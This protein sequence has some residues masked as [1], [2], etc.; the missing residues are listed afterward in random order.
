[1]TGPFT[2]LVAL[3]GGPLDGAR[4]LW[5][6]PG[7]VICGAHHAMPAADQA[8][9]EQLARLDLARCLPYRRAGP[10]EGGAAYQHAPKARTPIHA[11]C[12]PMAANWKRRAA[13]GIVAAS[14]SSGSGRPRRA[15]RERDRS[16]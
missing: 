4:L 5:L 3:H 8:T 10:I 11:L 7:R 1:M 15:R 2:Q 9:A 14:G 16:P 12:E 6:R 13:W